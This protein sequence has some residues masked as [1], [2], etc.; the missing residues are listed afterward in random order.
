MKKLNK[1]FLV[2]EYEIYKEKAKKCYKTGKLRNALHYIT[3]CSRIAEAYPIRRDFIDDELEELL[4]KIAF[5]LKKNSDNGGV[6]KPVHDRK[7]VVFYNGQIIDSGA[8]TEQYLHYL[9]ENDYSILFII[10]DISKTVNGQNILKFIS[11]HKQIKVF[12]PESQDIIS[13]I[14]DIGREIDMYNPTHA[15]LHFVPTDTVGYCVFAT[16]ENLKRYYIVHNDHTFWLGKGCSDYFLEFRKFG[17][18][19]SNRRRKIDVE[20]LLLVPFYPIF[21]KVPFQG[22]P[23]DRQGKVVGFSAANLYKYYKDPNLR[24]FNV[25]K[26]LLNEHE[27]FIFCLAGYG[28]AEKLMDF[29]HKNEL[30]DRF[31][32]LGKRDDFYELVG[33]VDILFES[34]PF[35]GGLTVLYAVLQNIPVTGIKNMRTAT[36]T[37]S[38]FFDLEVSYQ[39]PAN[40]DEFKED[41][42]RLIESEKS[43]SER[44]A[45]FSNVPNTK[46]EFTRRL[47]LLMNGDVESLRRSY[48]SELQYDDEFALIE[49]LNLPK[50]EID[51][52]MRKLDML[53]E[54]LT[55][56]DKLHLVKGLFKNENFFFMRRFRWM[57]FFLKYYRRIYNPLAT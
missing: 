24:Y 15:F 20:K 42:S 22:L 43:R 8:L 47:N 29:I 33:N 14:Y 4:G 34:Y 31:F 57:N 56:L 38:E 27:H 50:T 54:E 48:T 21:Q 1:C 17:H 19:I 39:E 36:Q 41:A 30:N 44:A 25:I 37:T 11:N 23:F 13:K 49:Y 6:S 51:Y 12:I 2:S 28:N 10:P 32:Y 18:Q 9:L 7:R 5:E 3:F 55:W 46:E 16:R 45:T 53:K 40:F 35:K 52:A 26:D